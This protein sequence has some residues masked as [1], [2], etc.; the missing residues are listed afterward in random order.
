MGSA[1][2]RRKRGGWVWLVSGVCGPQVSGIVG[3]RRPA[4][5]PLAFVRRARG[6]GQQRALMDGP[7]PGSP[8]NARLRGLAAG[9][10]RLMGFGWLGE[11]AGTVLS[12]GKT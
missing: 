4:A 6:L 5:D 8:A 9:D 1:A 7:R 10:A 3:F 2:G 12:A 11:R